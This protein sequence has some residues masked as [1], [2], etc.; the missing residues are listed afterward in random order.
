MV[1]P[2]WLMKNLIKKSQM[3]NYKRCSFLALCCMLYFP[4]AAQNLQLHYDARHSLDPK[5]NP[6][7]FPTLYFEY[8][9]SK[10][11]GSFLIKTQADFI[12]DRNNIGKFYMQVSHSFRFWKPKIFLQLEYSGGLGIAEPGAYGYYINNAFS[13]GIAHPFQWKG[14]FLNAYACYT[15]S[16]FKKASH[17]VLYSFYW[18]KGFFNYK[19]EFAG[20][21]SIWTRNKNRG[22]EYTMHLS[23]KRFYFFAEP[24]FWFNLD[25]KTALGTRINMYYHVYMDDNIFQ[26]YPTLAI[27]YKYAGTGRFYCRMV[28][29]LQNTD[30]YIAGSKTVPGRQY[31]H[32]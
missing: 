13:L 8:F 3:D 28:R 20:D 6:R 18:F 27:K 2:G 7:N 9:K 32:Y 11:S 4:L 31:Y 25:K 30:P 22:D 16:P 5:R 23:G 12:G 14:A 29:P 24:Q 10:D 26:A 19:L 21:F 15:Y 17:D 1:Q